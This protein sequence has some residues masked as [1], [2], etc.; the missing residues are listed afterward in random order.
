V[1]DIL[2]HLEAALWTLLGKVADFCLE[3]L[4]SA[5]R[6]AMALAT[7]IAG[8]VESLFAKL[9]AVPLWISLPAA[10]AVVALFVCYL[11]RQ[12]LYDRVLVYHLGWLRAKG[13]SRQIFRVRRGAVHETHQAMARLLPLAERFSAITI[14][15]VHPDQYAVAYGQASGIAE[16]V[17]FYR[18]DLKAG[19]RAMG[20]EL[21]EYFRVNVRMLHADSELRALFVILDAGDPSFRACRPALPGEAKEKAVPG[22]SPETAH[23]SLFGKS[24]V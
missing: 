8:G 14:Y 5:G 7:L 3:L 15:E 22:L 13:F 16:D 19:L 12:R 18:R 9:A 11:L 2:G 20:E 24:T 21:I 1:D 4:T 10:V 17:R 23:A 6:K